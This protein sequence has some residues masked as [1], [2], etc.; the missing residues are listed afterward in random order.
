MILL[1]GASGFIGRAL[2][3]AL[4]KRSPLRLALRDPGSLVMPEGVEVAR[5]VLDS[6]EDWAGALKDVSLVI[7]CAARVHVMKEEAL[8][9][10]V[11]FRSVNVEGTLRLA[12]QAAEAGVRRF[13]FISSIGVN[14][15]DTFAHPFAAEDN[16]APH[17]PY[18]ISKHEAEVGL[19][20]LADNTKMEIVIIRPPLVYGPNAPGNF[21][22]L[23]NWLMSGIPL[24]LGAVIENRRSF[25]F[26]DNLVDLIVTC[27]DHPAAANQTFLVSDG[28]SLSTAA[29]LRR[30]GEAL[31][32]PA[33]LI[34]VPVPLLQM[35]AALLGKRDMAQRLCG[36][37]EVDIG[38]TRELLG[39]TPPISVDE[40]LR[41]TAAHWLATE[42]AG[43]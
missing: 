30:M 18:A 29:L 28:E 16:V 43:N 9:P 20:A 7:H 25:V 4:S 40:G 15:G 39:W 26:I 42:G 19:R 38:K 27:L 1:T 34:Q 2:W 35:G 37:L 13:I 3:P 6:G 23:M 41:R 11:E 21:L 31:G 12:R 32:R 8:D 10:L 24:P 36:S 22:S 17:T 5:A 33:R 14:G